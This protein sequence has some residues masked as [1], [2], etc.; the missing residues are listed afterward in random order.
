MNKK[1][2]YPDIMSDTY[3]NRTYTKVS[4]LKQKKAL[5]GQKEVI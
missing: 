4:L 3:Y 2:L 5:S 1:K